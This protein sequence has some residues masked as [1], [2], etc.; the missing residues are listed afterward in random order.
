[1]GTED[2]TQPRLISGTLMT[3]T[4]EIHL[5][6]SLVDMVTPD[7]TCLT[8]SS[9]ETE[10]SRWKRM[11]SRTRLSHFLGITSRTVRLISDSSTLTNPLM[12]HQS[13]NQMLG[14]PADGA[15]AQKSKTTPI[16]TNT[17]TTP[18]TIQFATPLKLLNT[19]NPDILSLLCASSG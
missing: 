19:L 17:L 10:R 7:T 12:N 9:K 16:S 14:P 13:E 18:N 1:M 8:P 4:T 3:P 5:A 2:H 15:H 11:L 6:T